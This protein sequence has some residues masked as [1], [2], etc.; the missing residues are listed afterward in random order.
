MN[1]TTKRVF[2]VA[3]LACF[4]GD[5]AGAALVVGAD[6]GLSQHARFQASAFDDGTL[7]SSQSSERKDAF[8]FRVRA[9]VEAAYWL[10]VEAAYADLGEAEFTGQ[11]VGCTGCVRR[12]A[13]GP[14]SGSMAV[15]GE[16]LGL[17]FRWP[18]GQ[19]ISMG[20]RGGLF[21]W[22]ADASVAD[23]NGDVPS[24]DQSGNE[25]FAGLF[26]RLPLA[27]R[28]SVDLDYSAYPL[29]FDGRPSPYFRSYRLDLLAAGLAWRFGRDP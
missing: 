16:E 6:A 25:F 3:A 26:F 8:G 17:R 4:A 11:S 20:L 10:A 29:S 5:A 28:L 22:S 15:T 12:Y 2:F 24:R 18:L 21:H 7:D 19:G 1:R 13:Q 9:G 23:R 27:G 14:V